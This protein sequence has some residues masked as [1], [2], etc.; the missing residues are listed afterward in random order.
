MLAHLRSIGHTVLVYIDDTFLQ[1][2]THSE[3]KAAVASDCELLDN[4][5][6]TFHSVKSVF[7]PTQCIEFLGFQVDSCNMLVP[8]TSDKANKIRLTCERFLAQQNC[9]IRQL[10]EIIGQM[11]A[12]QPCF[13]GHSQ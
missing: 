12:A 8:L 9:G 13:L 6:F 10:A 7:D 5:G 2:D 1:G 4:L 3:C 11:V